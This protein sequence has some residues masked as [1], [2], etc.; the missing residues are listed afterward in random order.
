VEAAVLTEPREEPK[1]LSSPYGPHHGHVDQAAGGADSSPFE[2]VPTGERREAAET[3]DRRS[4]R[5]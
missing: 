1:P 4:G 5:A 2:D 3:E